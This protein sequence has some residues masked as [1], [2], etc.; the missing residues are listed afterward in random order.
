MKPVRIGELLMQRGLLGQDALLG[1]LRQQEQTGDALGTVLTSDGTLGPRDLYEALA[2]QR[3]LEFADLLREPPE[4]ALVKDGRAE[5][6]LAYGCMPWKRDGEV[7]IFACCAPDGVAL[8]YIRQRMPHGCYALAMTSPRDILRSVEACFGA[9]LD[10]HARHFLL[11]HAPHYSLRASGRTRRWQVA[12]LLLGGYAALCIWKP[13]LFV[14]LGIMLCNLF[15]LATMA[16]KPLL[17]W[18]A[19]RAPHLPTADMMA[20]LPAD[21]DLPVYTVLV[22][23]YREQEVIPRLVAALRALDYPKSRLDV[24]LVVEADDEATVAAILAAKPPGMFELL[25]VP[26]SL[27]RTKPKACNYAL[28]FARGEFITIFD[29]EDC[30]D[31][32]QLKKAVALFRA[33]PPDVV[34]L[35][36]RLRYYNRPENLLTRFFAI[37]Y[38]A[39][40]QWMLPGLHALGVPIPLGG[41]S[42]HLRLSAL[43]SLGEWDPYNVTEDADLGIR[44]ATEGW[45]TVPFDSYTEEEAPV[46][47]SAWLKQRARWIKGYM[48]TWQ[49]AMRRAEVLYRRFGCVGFAGFQ[50]FVGAASLVYVLAPVLWI[51]S[52]LWAAGIM[53]AMALPSWVLYCSLMV[54]SFGMMLQW[55]LAAVVVWA[56][57]WKEPGMVLAMMLYPFYWVLHSL[58]SLRALWQFFFAPHYWDKTPHGLSR[59]IPA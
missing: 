19:R 15:Y 36:A 22:P 33:L 4:E 25:R 43:R 20:A 57:G 10:D 11:R 37:E 42:N 40:F 45:K 7:T 28:H 14:S 18:Q 31:P 5:E 38:G 50:L 44:L 13:V 21:R 3:G 34:C 29:A 51:V 30:P 56:C 12:A 55:G 39:L 59:L 47:V 52:G 8:D 9:V 6:Y 58:A 27:P 54:F 48:Q 46:L 41:T 24:K 32:D 2:Q 35:Q 23:L 53:D 16:F 1:A 17:F 49:V 26:Y